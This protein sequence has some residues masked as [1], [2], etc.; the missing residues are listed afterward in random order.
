[1]NGNGNTGNG[2]SDYVIRRW[3]LYLA[4]IVVFFSIAGTIFRAGLTDAAFEIRLTKVEA[5]LLQIRAEY[6]RKDVIEQR[7]AELE[8]SAARLEKLES[9]QSDKL[10]RLL[11]REGRH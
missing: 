8:R 9:E 2:N 6:A 3:Q 7:L 10:D 11:M 5:D 1:M 4:V